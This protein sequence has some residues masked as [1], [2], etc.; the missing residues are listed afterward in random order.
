MKSLTENWKS[1]LRTISDPWALILLLA[2]GILLYFSVYENKHEKDIPAIYSVLINLMLMVSSIVL[3]ARLTKQWVDETE[4][5]LLVV[6]GKTAIRNLKLL[7]RN[8][9]G[10]GARVR[11]LMQETKK[12]SNSSELITTRNY[13]EIIN[14]CDSLAEEAVNSIE[15]WTDIIPEADVRTQI[16]ELTELRGQLSQTTKE[17]ERLEKES[18]D[19]QNKS[20]DEK[21]QMKKQIE[22]KE[23]KI[24]ELNSQILSLQ[25]KS[26]PIFE[27]CAGPIFHLSP[28]QANLSDVLLRPTAYPY[29]MKIVED[30]KEIK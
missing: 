16:G 17:L 6:R 13:E 22:D 9:V 4:S 18:K 12:T 20:S 30:K 5:G 21:S 3:G 8:I 1:F 26:G 2:T 19:A 23:S 24:R 11:L 14:Q 29:S 15:N 27:V 28:P 25:T 7:M 10:L